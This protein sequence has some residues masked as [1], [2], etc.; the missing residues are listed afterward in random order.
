M[1][2]HIYARLEFCRAKKWQLFAV[3]LLSSLFTS[4]VWSAKEPVP[5]LK[6]GFITVGPV[7][8]NG[9][10]FAHQKGRL[11]L[12]KEMPGQVQTTIVEKVPESAEC[13]RVLERLIGQGNKL[14]FTTSYGFLEPALRVA[15]R[16]PD[17]DFM[18]INRFQTAPNL[19]TY[20]SN[21]YQPM[22]FAGM[23]AGH[24]TKTNKLGFVGAHPVPP[25]LQA[26]NAFTMGARSV[27]PKVTTQVIWINNWTDP[28]LEADAIKSLAETH[29][30]VI[31]HAQDN[32][33]T[34]LPTCERLGVY[35]VG[36]YTDGHE[37]A[38]KGWLTGP[39]LEW[40]PFYKK[41]AQSVYNGKWQSQVYA[42][43]MEGGYVKL[44]TFGKAVPPAVQKEV[45]AKVKD[46]E[47]GKFVIFEGPLKD[48]DGT[49]R[50]K[51]GEKPDM[52]KLAEMNFLVDGV[53]GTLAKK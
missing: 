52:K 3:L 36:F 45:L 4:Q 49:L 11:Y 9:F 1:L 46:L 5:P 17:V 25:L 32:Q 38:P 53:Q 14:I 20:F 12:E 23:V 48:K 7:T 51:A 8:D 13:E 30:D 18:Q 16:H 10:N 6:I 39:C 31:A 19:S 21:Q 29:C 27:N 50:Y 43:G 42:Q 34:V 47:G 41:I 40:G 26:V 28:A 37:L 22:Y 15:A 24:M 33:N 35:S 2:K 44:A